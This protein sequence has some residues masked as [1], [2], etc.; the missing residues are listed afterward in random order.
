MELPL[1]QYHSAATTWVA[2]RY[3][4]HQ[5]TDVLVYLAMV[6]LRMIHAA[7]TTVGHPSPDAG[8][9]SQGAWVVTLASTGSHGKTYRHHTFKM[10]SLWNT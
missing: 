2:G 9:A 6:A 3:G 7:W 4:S 8:T 10:A 5:Y 1:N